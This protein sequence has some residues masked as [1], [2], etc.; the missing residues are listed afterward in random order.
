MAK[1]L[2][3]DKAQDERKLAASWLKATRL[4]SEVRAAQKRI[5]RQ[6]QRF[7]NRIQRPKR[8]GLKTRGVIVTLEF[9]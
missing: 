5:A 1:P 4:P 6:R 9:P 7:L 3:R 8:S 2:D